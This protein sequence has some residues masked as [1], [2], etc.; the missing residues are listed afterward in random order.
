MTCITASPVDDCKARV[1]ISTLCKR[2]AEAE[3]TVCSSQ[4]RKSFYQNS[5]SGRPGRQA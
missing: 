3:I 2:L 4:C 1:Q 5:K